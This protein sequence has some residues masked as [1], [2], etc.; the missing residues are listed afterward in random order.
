MGRAGG[1]GREGAR[2]RA[3]FGDGIDA[4]GPIAGIGGVGLAAVAL[5]AR[6]GRAR[7]GRVGRIGRVATWAGGVLVAYTGAHVWG[8]AVGK[9]R[10]ARRL[11]D[12]VP[13]RGDE[14][15]LDV[16]CGHGALLVE[17]ARRLTTGT[18]VGI[19]LWSTKDQ[20][21]N[22][23]AGPVENAR[24]WGVGERVRVLSG[25]ARRL[26]FP[27]GTFDVVVSGIVLH[28]IPG[29]DDRRRALREVVRVLAPGG[30]V[31]ILD[32]VH[33][34]TYAHELREAGLADVERSLPVPDYL[35][36]ARAVTARAVGGVSGAGG[37][38]GT[39]GGPTRSA[40]VPG[41]GGRRR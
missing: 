30:R 40:R 14:R 26:P 27:D 1:Q 32:L 22:R 11:L 37:P 6:A 15:V 12:G 2:G 36:T 20:W 28:N 16:G 10:A 25:D 13:W 39:P 23:P 4:P 21:R 34:A 24:R 29:E 3:W 38:G 41:R 33:T 5:G 35:V 31:I 18:A 7:R 9:R 19:D 8:S 17:A